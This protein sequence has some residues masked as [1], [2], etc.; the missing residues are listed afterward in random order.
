M[1]R[2]IRRGL[3]MMIMAATTLQLFMI[4]IKHK[5]Y[6]TYVHMFTQILFIKSLNI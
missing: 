5:S 1:K 4:M 2:V 3:T 6:K